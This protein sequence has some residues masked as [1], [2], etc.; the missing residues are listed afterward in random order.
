MTTN[1]TLFLVRHGNTG[2]S[3]RYIG[4][5]DIPLAA[6]GI[7]Q[8]RQLQGVFQQYSFDHVI[9]SPML[10]CRQSCEILFPEVQIQYCEELRE[11]NFGSWEGLTFE[12]IVTKD[13]STVTDW[14]QDP[15][16]FQFPDGEAVASFIA[17]VKQA[18]CL[19]VELDGKNICVVCHGGVI[20]GLLC[21]FL[22]ISPQ[23]YLLF[24]VKKGTYA[25]VELFGKEGVLTGLNLQ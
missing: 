3:G 2:Q 19:L 13:K 8:I 20:R 17:R 21:H 1:K 15:L 16:G 4:A 23:N 7:E 9:A 12:E 6:T 25:T 11:I 10:R 22:G 5:K 14:A 18:A 24:Q